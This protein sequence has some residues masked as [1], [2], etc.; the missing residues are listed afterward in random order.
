M[1]KKAI[2]AILGGMAVLAAAP[3]GAI[4]GVAVE[5]GRGDG[6]DTNLGRVAVQWDWGKR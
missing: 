5:L 2:S 6:T 3:A 4:D 1:K